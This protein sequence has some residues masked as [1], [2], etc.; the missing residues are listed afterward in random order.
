MRDKFAAS[1]RPFLWPYFIFGAFIVLSG[2]I[3][4][5]IP[6]LKRWQKD[7]QTPSEAQQEQEMGVVSYEDR[8]T[9]SC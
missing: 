2:I 4:F 5:G 7:H 8:N 6:T 3:L 1:P 9:T